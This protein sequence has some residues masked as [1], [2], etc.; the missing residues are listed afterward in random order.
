M[1]TNSH[2]CTY[3]R[4]L[5]TLQSSPFFPPPLLFN[6][7]SL[8]SSLSSA[9][10]TSSQCLSHS[11]LTSRPPE[12]SPSLDTSRLKHYC[13]SRKWQV[14]LPSLSGLLSSS[15]SVSVCSVVQQAMGAMIIPFWQPITDSFQRFLCHIFP[16]SSV[17]N[18][19][20]TQSESESSHR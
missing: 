4:A 16:S 9:R 17:Q 15:F 3:H 13:S 2:T 8:S 5:S 14:G 10:L 12:N 11:W 19:L 7:S 20:L 18:S 6:S 1:N